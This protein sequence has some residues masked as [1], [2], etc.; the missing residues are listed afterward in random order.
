MIYILKTYDQDGYFITEYTND[1]VNVAATIKHPMPTTEPRPIVTMPSI[2]EQILAETQ[3][4]TALFEMN[5]MG[6][7]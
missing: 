1:G 6:G 2:E 5:M 7:M 3:Y 4:Q